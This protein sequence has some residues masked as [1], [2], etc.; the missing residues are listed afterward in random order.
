MRKRALIIFDWPN[1]TAGQLHF[2]EAQSQ[3]YDELILLIHRGSIAPTN[4]T[5]SRPSCGALMASLNTLLPARLSSPYYLFPVTGGEAG[6]LHYW[7]RCRILCPA[8][9]KVFTDTQEW[10]RSA[11]TALRLPV[12]WIARNDS[13]LPVTPPP[14]DAPGKPV[15]RGLFITR[16]QPFHLGHAA[17]LEQLAAEQEEVIVILAMANR[18]HQPGDIATAGERMEMVLPWLAARLP[19]RSYLI[20]LPYSDYTME[21]IYELDHLVP[22][23]SQIYTNNPTIEAMAATAGYGIRRLQRPVAISGTMIRDCILRDLPYSSYVPENVYRYLQHSA[24]P[25]RLKKLHEHESR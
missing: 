14:A 6:D 10:Q 9:E 15:S 21:N 13:E 25:Q 17:F 12:E 3:L 2:L 22:A 7:L 19:R 23:F 4:D 8:F 5:D 1:L 20:P 24:I 11:Q 16:A 18:S